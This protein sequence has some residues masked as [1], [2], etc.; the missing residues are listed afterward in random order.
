MKQSDRAIQSVANE[1][2]RLSNIAAL[3]FA[4]DHK[5]FR[6]AADRNMR[7]KHR[8]KKDKTKGQNFTELSVNSDHHVVGESGAV[9]SWQL[10]KSRA[11]AGRVG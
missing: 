3:I 8:G 7:T 11:I 9:G 1:K 5:N 4:T 2:R 10:G 6:H